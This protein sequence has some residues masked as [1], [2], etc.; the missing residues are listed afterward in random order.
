MLVSRSSTT[1]NGIKGV[2]LKTRGPPRRHYFVSRVAAQVTTNV[3]MKYCT[4]KDLSTIACRKLPSRRNDIKAFQIILPED[5][6][7]E[8]AELNE[9][10]PQHVIQDRYFLNDEASSWIKSV[11]STN[12]S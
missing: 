11:T 7:T 2:E 5:Q 12:G 8:I 10:W 1:N 6:K 9:T 3:L 4:Q